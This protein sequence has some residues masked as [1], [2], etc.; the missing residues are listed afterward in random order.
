MPRHLKRYQNTGQLHFVTFS[1]YQRRPFLRTAAKRDI[2]LRA[3]E[4]ARKRFGFVV[5]GYVVMPEHV[6][7]LLSEPE[8]GSL[9]TSI[10]LVKQNSSRISRRR[11]RSSQQELF[12]ESEVSSPFWQTRYYDFNVWTAKKRIEKLK[13]MH[14]NPVTRG[15][16]CRAEDWRWSSY[17][18]YALEERGMVLLNQWAK[19]RLDF[20]A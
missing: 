18:S 17:R 1:C 4:Q 16:C 15:L 7:L 14:R 10:R 8:K 5:V 13:Y 2:F 12:A 6:H 19:I 9:A 3:L 11:P 20:I